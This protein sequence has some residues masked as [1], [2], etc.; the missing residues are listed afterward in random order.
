MTPIMCS[1]TAQRISSITNLVVKRYGENNQLD[2]DRRLMYAC[3]KT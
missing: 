3:L 2:A 1:R